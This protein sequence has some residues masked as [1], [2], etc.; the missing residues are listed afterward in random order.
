MDH[1]WVVAF[2]IEDA[3]LQQRP[4][5]GWADQHHQVFIQKDSSHRVPNCMP[6][7]HVG[8]P[9]LSRR[10]TDPH[11]DNIDCLLDDIVA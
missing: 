9:V 10:L 1:D 11:L 6:Y 7:L 3:N 4:I 8:D 2:D 5:N